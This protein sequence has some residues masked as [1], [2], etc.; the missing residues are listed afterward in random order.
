MHHQFYVFLKFDFWCNKVWTCVGNDGMFMQTKFKIYVSM[1]PWKS[2]ESQGICLELTTGDPGKF[3]YFAKARGNYRKADFTH[4]VKSHTFQLFALA[5]HQKASWGYP[6]FKISWGDAT[7]HKCD[8]YS[9]LNGAS[10]WWVYNLLAHSYHT[11]KSLLIPL[12]KG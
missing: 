11:Q 9:I 3:W 12:W 1:C 4:E 10:P 7:S 5:Y 6:N 2:V 8:N